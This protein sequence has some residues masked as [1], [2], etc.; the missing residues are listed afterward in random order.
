MNL[1]RFPSADP[2]RRV[3]PEEFPAENP[4]LG[5][6]IR[7]QLGPQTKY[8]L[9]IKSKSPSPSPESV[10][11]ACTEAIDFMNQLRSRDKKLLE[12]VMEV[13]DS[14]NRNEIGE[15][16]AHHRVVEL[17]KGEPQLL[18]S[19]A[20]FVPVTE[21]TPISVMPYREE[22]E[23]RDSEVEERSNPKRAK[24][25]INGKRKYDDDTVENKTLELVQRGQN[26]ESIEEGE[27]RDSETEEQRNPEQNYNTL[28]DK[29]L[30]LTLQ[31]EESATLS[32]RSLYSYAT[33]R[34]FDPATL[35]EE[36]R[37]LF[38]LKPIEDGIE[39]EKMELCPWK[40]EIEEDRMKMDTMKRQLTAATDY[41]EGR[42]GTAAG[43]IELEKC[44]EAMYGEELTKM[45]SGCPG[46]LGRVVKKRVYEKLKELEKE[47]VGL[48]KVWK[49]GVIGR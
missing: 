49:E 32:V 20:R 43:R 8:R 16:D 19:F 4:T 21:A 12:S 27:I 22:G 40:K 6:Q 23:I 34:S 35:P 31:Y 33:G 24:S 38:R 41:L 45:A 28:R 13:F 44:V 25:G 10:P 36:F 39:G 29:I 15:G 2:P 47:R 5:T 48:E 37:T 11:Q 26:Q 18:Q 14:R 30:N 1:M 9:R 3:P 46:F 7:N 17:I 42:S